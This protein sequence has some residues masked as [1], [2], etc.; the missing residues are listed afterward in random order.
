MSRNKPSFISSLINK[1][2][3]SIATHEYEKC[4]LF[5]LFNW[6]FLFFFL[7]IRKKIHLVKYQ[8][9][10][11]GRILCEPSKGKFPPRCLDETFNQWQINLRILRLFSN[12]GLDL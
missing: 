11:H 9:L 12:N 2:H 1:L 6:C 5:A 7:A 4:K 8:K 10:F 3:G